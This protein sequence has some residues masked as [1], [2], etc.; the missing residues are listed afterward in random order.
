ML[1]VKI[2]T[3]IVIVFMLKI[4]VSWYDR[5]ATLKECT[6]SF[7]IFL[8]RLKKPDPRFNQRYEGAN[9]RKLALQKKVVWEYEYIKRKFC[10][11]CKDSDYPEFAFDIGFWNGAENWPRVS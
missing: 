3:E 1:C 11:K 2:Y 5:K 10:K 4:G 8:E 6:E 9:S 7:I